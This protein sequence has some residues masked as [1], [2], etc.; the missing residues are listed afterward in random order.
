[1]PGLIVSVRTGAEAKN[2]LA[3]GATLLDIKEPQL[4]SLGRATDR[5]INEIVNR[6]S[7]VVCV[8]A[9]MGELRQSPQLPP[10]KDLA[11]VKWGLSG[12]RQKDWPGM[13]ETMR[14]D[15]KRQHFSC[16]PV[17]V[18][19]ADWERACSPSPRLLCDFACKN[20][21]EVLL[22]DTWSKDGTTLLNCI[23]L[24]E[25][26]EIAAEC[27]AAEVKLALAGS[28]GCEGI[29]NLMSVQPDW[30]AVRGAACRHGRRGST[31]DA[32]AVRR[33]AA[34]LGLSRAFLAEVDA[35]YVK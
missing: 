2:A 30:F 10:R 8:S 34:V 3:G 19:Y 4:G 17:V 23:S 1:M 29:A 26:N 24:N 32:G 6:F 27:A 9:A 28:L 5:R 16:K 21:F 7:N 31:I 13:L 15:L 20:K 18:A 22:I 11:F 25:L 33:I 12:L 35:F 14:K